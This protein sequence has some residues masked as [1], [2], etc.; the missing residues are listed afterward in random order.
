MCRPILIIGGGLGGLGLAQAL[1][2]HDVPF[3]L[4]ERDAGVDFRA[5]GYR[6]HI[7]GARH[8]C[9]QICSD[10]RKIQSFRTN[11]C[12]SP[13][14]WR[15]DQTRRPLI[16]GPEPYTV[17]RTTFRK[18]LLTGLE[19]DVFLGKGL[20]HCTLMNIAHLHISLMGASRTVLS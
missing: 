18:A 20:D 11:I 12:R 16:K 2:K 9:S 4:F 13:R 19:D 7:S 1:K 5:K 14:I 3:K 6:A 10:T 15:P 8:I 17:D